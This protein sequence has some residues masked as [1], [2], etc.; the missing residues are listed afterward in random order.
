MTDLEPISYMREPNEMA[1][2]DTQ[3]VD[4][5]NDNLLGG[6]F[7]PVVGDDT[8]HIARHGSMVDSETFRQATSQGQITL[9]MHLSGH[10]LRRAGGPVR[11]E[12]RSE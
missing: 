3:M 2:V 1:S 6:K 4:L 8:S 11:I 5:E 10:I 9:L 12:Q 7:V